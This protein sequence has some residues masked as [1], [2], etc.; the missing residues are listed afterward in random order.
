MRMTVSLMRAERVLVAR[1]LFVC[2][3]G[4]LVRTERVLVARSLFLRTRGVL[5]R[6][7]RV[8]VARSGPIPIGGRLELIVV[9]VV[10]RTH[11][12]ESVC[13]FLWHRNDDK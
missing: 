13:V 7:E 6:A 4:V 8:L 9:R 11:V 1:S 10:D 2:T 3:R 12:R 5:V